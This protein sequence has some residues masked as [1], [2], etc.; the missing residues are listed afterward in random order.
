METTYKILAN[1]QL[2]KLKEYS[3]SYGGPETID[4]SFIKEF[5]N[6]IRCFWSDGS[7][8]RTFKKGT[9]L[10]ISFK[11]TEISEKAFKIRVNKAIKANEARQT[12]NARLNEININRIKAIE[13]IQLAKWNEFLTNNPEKIQKYKDKQ[14][15][16][17][18]SKW[19]NLLRLKFSK[20]C[21]NDTF[22]GM[23]VSAA[24]L[25]DVLYSF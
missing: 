8:I 11:G 23:E 22:D 15:A 10:L 2:T 1:C 12:E 9:K 13:A 16:L 7:H 25:R 5:N 18:S 4:Y 6:E 3:Q 17:P 14:T 24:Q 19:R 20:H 21:N